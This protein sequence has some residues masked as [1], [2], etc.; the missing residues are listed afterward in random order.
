MLQHSFKER[1]SVLSLG[2]MMINQGGRQ[3]FIHNKELS[4]TGLEYNL[5]SLLVESHPGIVE[6]EHIAQNVF[7]REVK[8][9][10][11]SINM[12]I[13]NLRHKIAPLDASIH[14]HAVRNIGYVIA[15]KEM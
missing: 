12:H 9:C 4:L 6:R 13:S 8:L 3:V 1:P 7:Y 15:N 14:I 10:S 11:K 2:N 5:L